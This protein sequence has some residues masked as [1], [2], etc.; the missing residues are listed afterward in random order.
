MNYLT[1]NAQCAPNAK[2]KKNMASSQYTMPLSSNIVFAE[3]RL[4][5]GGAKLIVSF[6][7]TCVWK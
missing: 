6:C 4:G 3:I 1:N 7:Q 2:C 5:G